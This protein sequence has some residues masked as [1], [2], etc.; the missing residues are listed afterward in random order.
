V[1]SA[2][3]WIAIVGKGDGSGMEAHVAPYPDN[4]LEQEETID[5]RLE[6]AFQLGAPE[7]DV[8][9]KLTESWAVVP[10]HEWPAEAHSILKI[11]RHRDR[12]GADWMWIGLYEML[13]PEQKERGG[14]YFGAGVAINRVAPLDDLIDILAAVFERSRPQRHVG[15]SVHKL[16]I[17][18]FS[19]PI[20]HLQ[21]SFPSEKGLDPGAQQGR[22]VAVEALDE[23]ERRLGID[24][25]LFSEDYHAF[26]TIYA[27]TWV[28]ELENDIFFIPSD[29]VQKESPP[30][31]AVLTYTASELL[32]PMPKPAEAVSDEFCPSDDSG[33]LGVSQQYSIVNDQPPIDHSAAI[34][35]RISNIEKQLFIALDKTGDELLQVL[36]QEKLA[37]AVNHLW[38]GIAVTISMLMYLIVYITGQ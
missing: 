10:K 38:I 35:Q 3:A 29:P 2:Q 15:K 28:H 4:M 34:L 37:R 13:P 19:L 23:K 16:D 30:R 25:A 18:Q 9:T 24:R 1:A 17:E 7:S 32:D 33:S 12:I 20:L 21:D 26:S 36:Q 22:F 31:A 27:G 14:F 8:D 6:S 5:G 11:S